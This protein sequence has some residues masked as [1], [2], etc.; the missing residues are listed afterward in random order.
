MFFIYII[1]RTFFIHI[2]LFREPTISYIILAL[3]R[4][5]GT[6]HHWVTRHPLL[7]RVYCLKQ[8]IDVRRSQ[9]RWRVTVKRRSIGRASTASSHRSFY[10]E[11]II[12]LSFPSHRDT[13]GEDPLTC[14]ELA[15]FSNNN[16]QYLFYI[17]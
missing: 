4:H 12:A 16:T 7:S 17:F 2:I 8:R 5:L 15:P 13:P 1:D 14:S 9:Y 10:P 6:Y 11:V 3:I